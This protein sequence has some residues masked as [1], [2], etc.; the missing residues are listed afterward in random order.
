MTLTLIVIIMLILCAIFLFTKINCSE[1]MTQYLIQSDY[2]ENYLDTIPCFIINLKLRPN[3][4]R[5]LLQ[6]Y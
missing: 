3:K 2:M 4:K 5:R 6:N 1:N